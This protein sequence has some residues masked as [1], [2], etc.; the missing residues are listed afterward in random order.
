MS[1]LSLESIIYA[2][3]ARNSKMDFLVPGITELSLRAK[4]NRSE[5]E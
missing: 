3:G 4:Y 1:D 2:A 5:M